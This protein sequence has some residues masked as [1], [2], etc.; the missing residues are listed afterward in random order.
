VSTFLGKD[1]IVSILELAWVRGVGLV[2]IKSGNFP[3]LED[4][5]WELKAIKFSGNFSTK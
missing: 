2:V 1:Q 4:Q 5:L 3:L